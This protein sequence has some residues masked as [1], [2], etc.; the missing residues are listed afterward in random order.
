M[1]QCTKCKE[2]KN[3]EEFYRD[4]QKLS[5]Y[6]PDCKTCNKIKCK[7]WTHKNPAQRRFNVLKSATGVNRDQYLEILKLQEGKCAICKMSIE[8]NNRNL[9]VD[10]CHVEKI[11]RGLLCTKCN[12]GI[13]YF[14]DDEALLLKAIHYLHNNFKYKK[15]KY[16]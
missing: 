5:G 1:I 9:S 10:H 7:G 14:N 12:F 11:V 16:K 2:F 3:Q 15:I 8:D 6:R 13:G 4:R